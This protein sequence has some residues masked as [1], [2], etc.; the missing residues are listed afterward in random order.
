MIDDYTE[1]KDSLLEPSSPFQ[2]IAFGHHR[3]P[4]LVNGFCRRQ[5]RSTILQAP[6]ICRFAVH[7]CRSAP[8][9]LWWPR[10]PKSAAVINNFG[11][12]LKVSF[13][14]TFTIYGLFYL[15]LTLVP[16]ALA[17]MVIG[18]S[19]LVSAV[20][21]HYCMPG[22]RM[23]SIKAASLA[24][25]LFGVSI[26][27]FS[28]LPWESTAG[29]LELGGI[30]VL[31]LSNVAGAMGNIMVSR[32]QTEL[33]PIFLNSTQIFIGGLCLWGLS[34]PIEESFHLINPGRFG[35]PFRGC[36]FCRHQLFPSGSSSFG[37]LA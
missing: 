31:L 10:R 26:L 37:V 22:D 6:C 18:A 5:N 25:G 27:S 20:L 29:L 3:L 8:D 14:Q 4:S 36:P 32:H 11:L 1:P 16:G 2:H 23:T 15:G 12:I 9:P 35:Y 19:P 13:F 34:L 7:A 33:E 17:A 24:L 30:A 28:R 21:A